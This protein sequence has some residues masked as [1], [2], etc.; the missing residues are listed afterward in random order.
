MFIDV[1]RNKVRHLLNGKDNNFWQMKKF[2]PFYFTL[3]HTWGSI[4]SEMSNRSWQKDS[5]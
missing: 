2:Y 5:L 4:P 3:L 1:P